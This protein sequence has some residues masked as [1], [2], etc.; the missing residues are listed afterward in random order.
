MRSC[1]TPADGARGI[2]GD[3]GGSAAGDQPRHVAPLDR[4]GRIK[5]ARD[6]RNRRVVAASEIDRLRAEERSHGITTRNRLVGTITAVKVDGL[7]AQVELVVTEPAHLVA[8]VTR[9][10]VEE[11]GL[12]PGMSAT[13]LVKSTSVMVEH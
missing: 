11:L 2:H 8:L 9:D 10:A 12:E 7:M 4:A 13:A 1:H 5:T 6:S 3:R